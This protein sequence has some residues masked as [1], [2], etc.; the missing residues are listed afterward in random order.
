M[1]TYA[2]L[3]LILVLTASVLVGCGCTNKNKGGM[4]EPTVLP[5]NEELWDVAEAV[6]ALGGD[7]MVETAGSLEGGRKVWSLLRFTDPLRV[8]G[9]PNGEAVA[10]FALQNDHSGRGSFRG[11]AINTRIVCAN[12][13]SAADAEAKRNGYEF[14]FR[15]TSGVKDRIEEAKAAVLMWRE[16]AVVW[17]NAMEHLVNLRVAPAQREAYVQRFQPMPPERL[18][19]DRVRNNV[20]TARAELRAIL[21]SE[22]CEGIDLTAYGLVQASIEWATHVRKTR[23]ATER[24]RMESRFKRAMLSTDRLGADIVALA[25]DAVHSPA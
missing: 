11:Q 25:Q 12:T 20:E 19:S 21:A 4:P 14:T 9:D 2:S 1:K 23:G 18:I 10:Y 6:G 15:H 8:K 22:T 3:V 24:D 5:T 13:S 16:G 7:I 17:Q